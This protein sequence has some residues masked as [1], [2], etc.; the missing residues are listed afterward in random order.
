V[1]DK[2][3]LQV[4]SL[5]RP[6]TLQRC[7]SHSSLI[8]LHPLHTG[9]IYSNVAVENGSDNAGIVS[10]GSLGVNDKK[11]GDKAGTATVLGEGSVKL[12]GKVL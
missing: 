5:S 2:I 1:S 7:Y 10:L 9:D 8:F 4:S 3:L 12:S 6:E 11:S